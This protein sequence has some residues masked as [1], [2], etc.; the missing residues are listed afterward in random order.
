M[1]F[2]IYKDSASQYRWRLRARNGRIIADSGEGYRSRAD[3][4]AAVRLVQAGAPSA[5][6]IDEALARL[7]YGW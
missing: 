3:C 1:T 7:A 6:T 4:E 5:R 2:T